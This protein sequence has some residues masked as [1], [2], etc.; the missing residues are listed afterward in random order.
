MAK[1][2]VSVSL[3]PSSRDFE[4]C[5]QMF[6]EDVHLRRF[7]TDGNVHRAQTL[8]S[9]FDGQ[10]DAIGLG[11]MSITFKVGHRT[12]LHQQIKQ[13]ASAARVTPV[14]DGLYLKNTLERWAIGQVAGREPG[15]FG[16]KQVFVVSG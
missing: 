16:Y 4:L 14:V 1:E 3:G 7:G 2:I 10:V 5:T 8:V 11:G 9:Q 13:V 15:I 12:Y 6:G